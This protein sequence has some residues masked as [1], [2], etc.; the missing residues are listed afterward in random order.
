MNKYRKALLGAAG[1]F[2]LIAA[3]QKPAHAA[4]APDDGTKTLDTSAKSVTRAAYAGAYEDPLFELMERTNGSLAAEAIETALRKMFADPIPAQIQAAPALLASLSGLGASSVAVARSRDV[5][6]ELVSKA[7]N[8]SDN[9]TKTARI[10]LRKVG[11][12]HIKLAAADQKHRR[13][14]RPDEVGQVG[15]ARRAYLGDAK[16]I[17]VAAMY[18]CPDGTTVADKRHCPPEVG[19]LGGNQN[20]NQGQSGGAGG[21]GFGVGIGGFHGASSDARLK[22]NVKTVAVL[23]NGLTLYSFQYRRDPVT[24]YVGVLAQDLLKSVKFRHAVV[25]GADG[26]YAVKYHE[27]GLRMFTLDEWRAVSAELARAA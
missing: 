11:A 17:R 8:V 13:R 24:T 14:R 3:G 15:G 1:L 16:S 25:V 22:M 7:Q 23:A 12:G 20:Q 10:E 6:I 4:V 21:F 27:L 9:V 2:A 5:L 18:H 26:Y 19:E